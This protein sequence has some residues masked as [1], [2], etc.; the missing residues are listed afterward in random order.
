MLVLGGGV[1]DYSHA[2]RNQKAMQASLDAAALAGVIGSHTPDEQIAV[3]EAYFEANRPS[4]VSVSDVS[5]THEGSVLVGTATSNVETSFLKLINMPELTVSATSS[6]TSEQFRDTTCV[7]AMHPT[8]KHTLELSGSVDVIGGDCNFY[9][10][11]TNPDDVVDPHNATNFLTGKSVQANGYGH[12]YIENVTPPLEHAPEVLSDPLASMVIPT[13]SAT[14]TATG[15]KINGGTVTLSPGTYCN[16]LEITNHATV[17]LSAGRYFIDQNK[18]KIADS[19]VTGTAGVTIVLVDNKS[20]IEWK[21][22][23]IRMK[24]PS[25]G[26]DKGMVIMGQRVNC[27]N[28]IDKA[29]VDLEGV[30]YLPNGEFNW[31]NT[32]TPTNNGK[33]TAWKVDGLSWDGDGVI[34]MNFDY[35]HGVPYPSA[36]LHV[37]PRMGTPRLKS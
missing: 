7:M 5:F 22:S 26:A 20:I 4:N 31:T 32:G 18:F 37:V 35:K 14:C 33:W 29:T 6:A 8:R 30:V 13:K 23:T 27:T 9:G 25:T 10:N 1:L 24:A 34:H 2:T 11:S 36:L 16:G 12:H 19:T 17:T 15:K 3:A 28:V 21:N